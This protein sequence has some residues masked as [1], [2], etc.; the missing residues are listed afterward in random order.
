L[1]P[2]SDS[3]L[4]VIISGLLKQTRASLAVKNR[5]DQIARASTIEW[6]STSH[7]LMQ[8]D[9]ERPDVVR[10]STPSPRVC[11]GDMYPL[12]HDRTGICFYRQYRRAL[13]P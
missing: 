6:H 7:D 2:E 10:A 8:D 11:S 13:R 9:A 1:N 12:P 5:N 4:P 3:L